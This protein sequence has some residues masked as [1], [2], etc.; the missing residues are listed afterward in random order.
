MA[1]LSITFVPDQTIRFPV[2]CQYEGQ[3]NP[4]PACLT[5]DLNTGCI[6]AGYQSEIGE[7]MSLACYHG[8][9]LHFG[10]HP[11]STAEEIEYMILSAFYNL[12]GAFEEGYKWEYLYEVVQKVQSIRQDGDEDIWESAVAAL[13]TDKLREILDAGEWV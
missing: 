13:Q 3:T 5:L 1:D 6:D 10:I 8:R 7:S 2:F 12:R 11:M 9:I 4:Q